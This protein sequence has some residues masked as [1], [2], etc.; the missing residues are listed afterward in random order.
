MQIVAASKLTP[1]NNY[2]LCHP[3]SLIHDTLPLRWTAV[4][5]PKPGEG[6]GGGGGGRG[7]RGGGDVEVYGPNSKKRALHR[8]FFQI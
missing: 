7:G 6:G 1:Y 4:V 8:N 3:I 5:G 2:V